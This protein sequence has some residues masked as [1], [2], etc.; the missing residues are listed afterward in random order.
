MKGLQ[1]L[2]LDPYLT[3]VL[4]RDLAGHDRSPAAFLVYLWLWRHSQGEGRQT[5]AAS[6]Q[7]IAD[8]T[9]L[10]KSAVQRAVAHLKRRAL[11]TARYETPTAAPLYGV[12][13]P[14]HRDAPSRR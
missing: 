6:L 9:G 7:M 8:G 12:A 10:S 3:D 14:W 13:A 4:M 1:R 2:E 11:L 5:M